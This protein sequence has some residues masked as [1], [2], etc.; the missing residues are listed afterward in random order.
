MK[1]NGF[2]KHQKHPNLLIFSQNRHAKDGHHCALKNNSCDKQKL[3][4]GWK[5][6]RTIWH[7]LPISCMHNEQPGFHRMPMFVCRGQ[8][9][10]PAS[11]CP[12]IQ[13]PLGFCPV[14]L[15]FFLTS[16]PRTQKYPRQLHGGFWLCGGCLWATSQRAGH[17]CIA[18]ALS[19]HPVSLQR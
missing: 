19:G 2:H 14:K 4:T 13:C 5:E 1:M 6:K 12:R 9:H 11:L 17:W 16:T 7:P 3:L 8:G 18:L 10:S 15:S